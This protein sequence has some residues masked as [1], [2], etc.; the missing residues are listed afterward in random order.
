MILLLTLVR[1]ILLIISL[2]NTYFSCCESL[3]FTKLSRSKAN[4][5]R[6]TEASVI[7]TT[8]IWDMGGFSH[9]LIGSQAQ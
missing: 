9:R 7:R 2:P 1:M 8:L 3:D 4:W 5:G 6:R